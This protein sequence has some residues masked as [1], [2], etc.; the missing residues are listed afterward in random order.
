MESQTC[1][2]VHRERVD[3]LG[4]SNFFFS[5][6]KQ[7]EKNRE[8]EQKDRSHSKILNLPAKTNTTKNFLL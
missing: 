8:N 4:V 7:Q 1:A 3:I 5:R 6:V 2:D